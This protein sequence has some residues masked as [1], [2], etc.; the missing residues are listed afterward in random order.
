MKKQIN[1]SFV[2][3]V[4]VSGDNFT[5]RIKETKR[6]KMDF[7]NGLNVVLISPRRMG[8]TSLIKKV[9]QSVDTEIIHTIYMDIYDCRS[10]YD[11]YNKFAESILKQ[12]SNKADV[13][14]ERVKNFLTRLT[15]K[16]SFNIDPN[17]D[18]SVSLGITPKEYKPEEI[19]QLPE[20]IAKQMGKHLVICIDEFQ[21]VAEWQ[22]SLQVQK[23][24]RGVWQHQEH[25]SYCIFGSKQ[26]MM[27]KLFQNKRMPFY[28]F[29][30]PNY[31]QPIPTEDWLPFIQRKFSDKGLVISEQHVKIICDVVQ[32]QSSYVQQLAWN[33]M[34]NT[35]QEVTLDCI[36]E[37]INDLL[38]QCTP[39]FMEQIGSLTG[40]QMNFLRAILSGQH[41]QFTSQTV[42]S[43]YQLGT[44]SNIS[45]MQEVLLEKDFIISTQEGIFLSDP[46]MEL[47]LKKNFVHK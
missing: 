6:L 13:F 25:V 23:R 3:G 45:R 28:Q 7:E 5:D 9:Q 35:E 1:K 22:D 26:H 32:N 2:Y 38:T 34:L 30:E 39:L 47:W 29:G 27:N 14:L 16:V 43:T 11:F 24:M 18:F 44:K 42:L 41:N 8:K 46:V 20:L 33:V 10:E 17:S 4:S 40:Y 15:P 36:Q 12:T 19:L 21:Q 37:G 31:L